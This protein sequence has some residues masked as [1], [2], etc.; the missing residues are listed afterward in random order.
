MGRCLASIVTIGSVCVV[1]TSSVFS[2]PAPLERSI[3]TSRQF[4]VYGTTT[5]L[6]GAIADL[7]EETKAAALNVLQQRD[8]WKIPVILSLQF[9]QANVPELSGNSLRFSQTGSGLKIQLDLT[10]TRDFDVL[11]IRR[12][13][14]R[15]LLLEMIYRDNQD[16]P[17]GTLYV[18]PPDWL[19]EGMLAADPLQNVSGLIGAVSALANDGRV[20]PVEQFLQQKFG[21][22]DSAG[23]RLYRGYS[24]AFLSLLVNEPNGPYRLTNYVMTLSKSSSDPIADLQSQ[25]PVLSRAAELQT[26]W[27]TTVS[28]LAFR[29]YQLFTIAQTESQLNQLVGRGDDKP[30]KSGVDLS[31]FIRKKLSAEEVAQ[32]RGLKEKLML[33]AMQANPILRPL[34]G[35]YEQ[36]VDRLLAHKIK[37]VPGRLSALA[38]KR[39]QLRT[40]TSDIDDYMN[41]FE[42][43]KSGVTS[44]AF[45]GYLRAAASS[46]EPPARRRDPLSVYL[47]ALEEQF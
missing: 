5:P 7:A 16:V 30:E 20:M 27:R 31:R 43:T 12:Q 29:H 41:W 11:V 25:F 23:Q 18:E 4:I 2:T 40:R 34:V 36:A 10:I 35:G 17:A 14:L 33:L 28:D 32:L 19:V 21:L 45:T 38:A 1:G 13:L 26:L 24:L 6:R 46:S 44:G 15:A 9:P 22:I 8:A 39:E 37:D 42:A 3:S 47:D